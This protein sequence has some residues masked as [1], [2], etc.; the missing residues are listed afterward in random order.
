MVRQPENGRK[1][2]PHSKNPIW[3]KWMLPVVLSCFLGGLP[4]GA[5]TPDFHFQD[6]RMASMGY[7][8]VSLIGL[9]ASPFM[10]PASLATRG[11]NSI[12]TVSGSFTD[13]I[14]F[15]PGGGAPSR[16]LQEPITDYMATFSG[17]NIALTVRRAVLLERKD[18][19]QFEFLA[20]SISLIQID[21]AWQFGRLALGATIRGGN[22]ALR[23]GIS[24]NE[25]YFGVD[26][27]IQTFFDRYHPEDGTDFYS[28]GAGLILDGGWLRMGIVSE[29]LASSGSP[30][31]STTPARNAFDSLSAG[32]SFS[33]SRYSPDYEL[34]LLVVEG[35]VDVHNF[36]DDGSRAFAAGINLRLQMLP[37]VSLDIRAGYHELKPVL[38]QLFQL[39]SSYAL[40][41]V[42]VAFALEG[43]TVDILCGIPASLYTGQPGSRGDAVTIGIGL[44]LSL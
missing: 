24:V 16:F 36:G 41:S 34:N 19:A 29:T 38:G 14:R 26:Y 3:K 11:E 10:N 40:T 9:S 12:L 1:Y 4:V 33:T 7:A 43:F 21:A 22:R 23:D 44:G 13:R 5:A 18:P 17:E 32:F 28:L 6:F 30:F 37:R 15:N 35:A 2:K 39:D 8:G 31:P 27:F 25:S 20:H 42:G